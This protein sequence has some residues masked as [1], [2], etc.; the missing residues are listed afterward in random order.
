LQP[1]PAAGAEQSK[2]IDNHRVLPLTHVNQWNRS[3]RGAIPV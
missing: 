1:K 3:S 2:S